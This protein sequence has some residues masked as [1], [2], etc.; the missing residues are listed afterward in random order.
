PH[1]GDLVAGGAVL[2]EKL[3]AARLGGS[4]PSQDAHAQQGQGHATHIEHHIDPYCCFGLLARHA[5]CARAW[6]LPIC[7]QADS[8]PPS[9]RPVMEERCSPARNR[10][11]SRSTRVG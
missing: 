7:C 1:A 5:A 4:P 2:L 6:S 3:L 9:F 10:R 11:P 8:V